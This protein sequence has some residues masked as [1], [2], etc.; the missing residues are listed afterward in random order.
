MFTLDQHAW[1]AAHVEASRFFDRAPKRLVPDKLRTGVNKPDLYD[2][3]M[4]KAYGELAAHY[5]AL[6]DP[7]RA[8]WPKDKPQVEWP[9]PYARDSYWRGREFASFEH[10]QAEAIKWCMKVAG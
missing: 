5:G 9:M 4:N 7:A 6:I 1:T 3:K 10:M 8:G 2:S